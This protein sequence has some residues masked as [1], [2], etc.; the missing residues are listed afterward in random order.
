M[1]E[2]DP[3]GAKATKRASDVA[4]VASILDSL[5]NLVQCQEQLVRS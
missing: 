1:T 2:V 5:C 3:W 4:R